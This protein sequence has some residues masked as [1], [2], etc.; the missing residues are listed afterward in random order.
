MDRHNRKRQPRSLIHPNER[1]A[2]L[3]GALYK[4]L[5]EDPDWKPSLGRARFPEALRE[6]VERCARLPLSE[7]IAAAVLPN[8]A[9]KREW[10]GS[11]MIAPW[12]AR[13]KDKRTRSALEVGRNI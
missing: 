7:E 8:I 9:Q 1:R 12:L 11:L 6:G 13:R 10:D 5:F 3:R 4:V 2:I